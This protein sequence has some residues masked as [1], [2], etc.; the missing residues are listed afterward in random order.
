[1][2]KIIAS[3]MLFLVIFSLSPSLV[4][5]KNHQEKPYNTSSV[6]GNKMPSYLRQGITVD[7]ATL[8]TAIKMYQQ[9]WR[10]TMPIPK[11]PQAAWG[12]YD[13]RTTWWYGYWENIKTGQMSKTTP[14]LNEQGKYIGDWQN[15]SGYYRNGGSP[16]Q[17]TKIEWLLS[18]SGGI[19]PE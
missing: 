2:K 13:G 14:L 5:A 12:N 7:K 17:P 11:S 4:S 19:K 15:M 10:Y 3:I 16:S 9:G 1:M 18:E 6:K 8:N